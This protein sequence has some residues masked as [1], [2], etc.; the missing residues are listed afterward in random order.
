MGFLL[1]T[2]GADP[3]KFTEDEWQN[4]LDKLRGVVSGGQVRAF[5]GNEY[6]QDLAA[7]NIVACEAWSGDV[8]QAQFDNPAI[9]FVAPEEGLMLWSDN[10]LVPNLAKHQKNAE[11]WMNYY[12]QPEVAAKLAAWVN[13]I[14]PV[15]GAR[16]EMEKIDPSLV[17]N[18]LI[19]PDDETL[20]VTMDFMALD[21][22]KI[23]QYEGEFADVTGG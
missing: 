15:Q 16:E 6:I 14:C 17:D 11:L 20:A 10:M 8:I 7:G 3:S 13:Y 12:Y 5:T 9:K 2:T 21:E 18:Q 4:A 1:R 23:T 19:F 22:A